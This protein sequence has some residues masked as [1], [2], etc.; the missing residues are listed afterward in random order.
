[1]TDTPKDIEAQVE[2]NRA[3][4]EGTL[5]ALRRKASLEGVVSD[6]GRYV[7]ITDTRATLESTGRQMAANP[8]AFGLIGLGIA[9]LATGMTR[10]DPASAYAQRP[11]DSMGDRY[12]ADQGSHSSGPGIGAQARAYA[13]QASDTAH[14]YGAAASSSAHRYSE[15]ASDAAHRYS[16]AASGVAHDARV[17]VQEGWEVTRTRAVDLTHQ[18]QTQPLLFGALALFA[19]AVIGS[20]LPKSN[21]E[22]R[23]LGPAHDRLAEGAREMASDLTDRGTAAV[24]AGLAAASDT[25]KDEGLIPEGGSTIAEKVQHVA[26]AAAEGASSEFRSSDKRD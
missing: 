25:A 14:R 2:A 3:N 20:T 1:M 16:E 19:G 22:N 11:Y 23:L 8:V 10:R 7:G 5:E 12:V 24:K 6:V 17:A 4:V 18:M 13:D 26:A 9:C 21:A 15:A